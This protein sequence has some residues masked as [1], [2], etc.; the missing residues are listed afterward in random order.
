MGR[1]FAGLG[2][3]AKRWRN[4]VVGE[5]L[6]DEANLHGGSSRVA[7]LVQQDRAHGYDVGTV[8]EARAS[9][10]DATGLAVTWDGGAADEVDDV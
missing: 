1:F 10:T 4:G 2:V 6:T 7:K 9:F 3:G 5:H 8:E